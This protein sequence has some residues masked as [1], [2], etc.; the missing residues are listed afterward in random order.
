VAPVSVGLC[1]MTCTTPKVAA[2]LE[3]EAGGS[4]AGV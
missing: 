1:L 2:Y 4:V 3:G